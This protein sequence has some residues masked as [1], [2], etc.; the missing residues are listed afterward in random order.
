[1]ENQIYFRQG[2]EA[3][4]LTMLDL[5]LKYGE[6]YRVGEHFCG[7]TKSYEKPQNYEGKTLYPGS[8]EMVPPTFIAL[9]N[10]TSM[11]M[12]RTKQIL[13]LQKITLMRVGDHLLQKLI[14]S[15]IEVQEYKGLHINL[16]RIQATKSERGWEIQGRFTQK[17]ME[18]R[19]RDAEQQEMGS[20]DV[21]MSAEFPA[22]GG[23]RAYLA[24]CLEQTGYKLLIKGWFPFPRTQ[25]FGWYWIRVLGLPLHLWSTGI[26]KGIGDKCVRR[27]RE[28][29][30]TSVEIVD[31]EWVL[32]QP[33]WV[34]SPTRYRRNG[35]AP[36]KGPDN[37][38][39][40]EKVKEMELVENHKSKSKFIGLNQNLT[41]FP[42]VAYAECARNDERELGQLLGAWAM[43]DFSEWINDIEH[44][45]PPLIGGYYTW[46]REDNHTTSKIDKFRHCSL[47]ECLQI[48]QNQLPKLTSDHNP[49]MLGK[50]EAKKG[51]VPNTL[52]A[53][54]STKDQRSFT[55]EEMLQKVHLVME[56]EENFKK[57][58]IAWRRRSRKTGD[59]NTKYFHRMAIAHKRFNL[60][61]SS[62]H[63][64]THPRLLYN[65][66]KETE[67]WRSD[68]TMQDVLVISGEEQV[69]MPWQI[70]SMVDEIWRLIEG[71]TVVVQ[72]I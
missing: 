13:S 56:H 69:W 45:D 59:K 16:W 39:R 29:T 49:V 72:H 8:A 70:I 40:N 20:A 58:H 15:L 11:L 43:T 1:M 44:I 65:L 66:Y 55:G 50:P 52:S 71:K 38:R 48:K 60:L 2:G 57:E 27:P 6:W 67:N 62:R 54:E 5:R 64:I 53:L 14:T 61:M 24:G 22:Q 63:Q 35:N 4:D 47:W 26:M 9:S 18:F 28:Q 3:Y 10:S 17:Q 41:W 12:D 51:G 19:R 37:L 36:D 7:Y 68:F 33:V 46:R 21:E 31:G 25:E 34:E 23:G 30:A 42:S 32:S